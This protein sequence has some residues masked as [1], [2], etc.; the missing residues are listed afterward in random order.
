MPPEW[1]RRATVS[2][3]MPGAP[4]GNGPRNG[5]TS[6]ERQVAFG[7]HDL[8]EQLAHRPD[9]GHRTPWLA[10]PFPRG[11]RLRDDHHLADGMALV[12]HAVCLPGLLQRET[13]G[14]RSLGVQILAHQ[15]FEQIL[16][17]PR[18]GHP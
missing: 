1:P 15:E 14:H 18:T 12:E 17:L 7:P 3:K 2:M 10:C 4:L 16:H 13:I 9:L 11:G 6:I 5:P 8:G